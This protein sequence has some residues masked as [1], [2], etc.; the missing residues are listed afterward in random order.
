MPTSTRV[1]PATKYAVATVTQTRGVNLAPRITRSPVWASNGSAATTTPRS[2]QKA[3][4]WSTTSAG[5]AK[6]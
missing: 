4:R 1:C 3:I 2:A 6:V 5:Q